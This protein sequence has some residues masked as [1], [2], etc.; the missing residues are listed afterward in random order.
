MG[1]A[2]VTALQDVSVAFDEGDFFAIM[3][4]SG[5]GKS[6]LLNLLGCLDRPTSGSYFLGGDDVAILDDDALSDIRSRKI[7]FIF[8]SFNLIPQ[9]TVVENI[10]VPLFYQGWE[11]RPS[12]ERAIEL[13]TKLGLGERLEHRPPQLSGGQQ[14]RVAIARSL[15]N[16]PLIILADEPTGNLDSVTEREILDLLA[17]LNRQGKTLIVVT[18]ADHVAARAHKVLRLRDGRVDSL[19]R[20][21]PPPP[22]PA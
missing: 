14:Q 5:S 1:D 19:R 10:E 17:E 3:G 20:N 16:D 8:Q 15:V 13:A 11:A 22:A 18:H 2:T 21:E 12:R 7:G 9:L 4:Q 6:T